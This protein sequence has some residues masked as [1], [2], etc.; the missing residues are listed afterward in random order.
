MSLF[1]FFFVCFFHLFVF[2]RFGAVEGMRFS[3]FCCLEENDVEDGP[4]S[5]FFGVGGCEKT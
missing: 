5:R 4:V 2:F 3:I 1:V